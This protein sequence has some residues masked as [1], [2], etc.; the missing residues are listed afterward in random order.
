M[1]IRVHCFNRKTYCL[2]R[3]IDDKTIPDFDRFIAQRPP[4]R[5][6]LMTGY[7]TIQHLVEKQYISYIKIKSWSNERLVHLN[8]YLLYIKV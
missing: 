7:F 5:A 4:I 3:L 1:D 2:Y 6:T 8:R